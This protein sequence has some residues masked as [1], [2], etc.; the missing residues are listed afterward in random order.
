[1]HTIC[2]WA[3]PGAGDGFSHSIRRGKRGTS[4]CESPLLQCAPATYGGP[5]QGWQEQKDQRLLTSVCV[6]VLLNIVNS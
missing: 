2:I 3:L 1:M 6:R 4:A 5:S